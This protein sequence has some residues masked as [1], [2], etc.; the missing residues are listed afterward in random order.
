[1]ESGNY[2]IIT[3]QPVSPQWIFLSSNKFLHAC[4]LLGVHEKCCHWIKSMM[5]LLS[6]LLK[7]L[8]F[9]IFFYKIWTSNFQ[10]I[11]SKNSKRLKPNSLMHPNRANQ[12]WPTCSVPTDVLKRKSTKPTCSS[13]AST[14]AVDV[15]AVGNCVASVASSMWRLRRNQRTTRPSECMRWKSTA[16]RLPRAWTWRC[17]NLSWRSMTRHV[18]WVPSSSTTRGWTTCLFKWSDHHFDGEWIW[19]RRNNWE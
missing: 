9:Q 4:T 14:A 15:A 7:N 17:S 13:S 2:T 12:P 18:G 11:L 1:M 5:M 19:G 3:H 16:W 10:R 8:T 6:I